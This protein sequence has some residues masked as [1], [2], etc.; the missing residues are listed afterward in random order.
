MKNLEENK[1]TRAM[2]LFLFV[3]GMFFL[4]A[5]TSPLYPGFYGADSALFTLLGKGITEGKIIYRDLFDHKG[6]ILF[7]IEAIGYSI[8]KTTGI[9][10]L[11]CLFGLV[12]IYFL[13][14]T[15]SEIKQTQNNKS[16]IDLASVFIAGC[17][18]LFYTF[19]FGNLS[20]EYSLPMISACI[21]LFVKY[22]R[23]CHE[24]AKHPYWYSFI[25]GAVI[26][27][28][29]LIRL[30]NSVTVLGG[31]FAI[32]LYL[33]FMKEYKNLFINLIF[34]VL[35]M[36]VVALPVAIYFISKSALHDMIYATFIYNFKY[37]GN[38]THQSI[39]ANFPKY[40]VLYA[41]IICSV[42]LIVLKLKKEKKFSF[43]DFLVITIV[44][45]NAV[46]LLIANVYPHYFT[47]FIPV[48]VLVLSAYFTFDTSRIK[49]FLVILCVVPY[50]LNIGYGFAN[51]VYVNCFLGKYKEMDKNISELVSEIP[52][53]ERDAVIGYEIP[54]AYYLYADIVPSFK[55][56]THHQ[57]WTRNDPSIMKSFVEYVE[58][59]DALWLLTLPNEDNERILSIISD[60]YML[61]EK[62][63]YINMYRIKESR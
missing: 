29:S 12:N 5:Y 55:Y 45:L 7:F 42:L 36:C 59:G 48:F 52:Q 47:I 15:W 14:S 25:Y 58:S 10:I 17:S 41:P 31:V 49:R 34:G 18:V 6:P 43:F 30:N 13:Y 24:K 62:N 53:N 44:V 27:L 57:W 9:F 35:G 11:Q 39:I 1:K 8:G 61:V 38:V 26:M 40:A 50:I 56:Y 54:P 28:L 22:A 33:L 60:K 4:S 19:Q 51:V 37:A 32:I 2:L 3:L 46:C 23:K 21:L 20:E 16:F 63:K